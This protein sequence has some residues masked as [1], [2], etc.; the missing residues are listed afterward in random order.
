MTSRWGEVGALAPLL[1][2]LRTWLS[3]S[4]RI[5]VLSRRGREAGAAST[6][7]NTPPS[8]PR[9]R[10]SILARGTTIAARLP[11]PCGEG[12]GSRVGVVQSRC[13]LKD[14]LPN[15]PRK[16]EGVPLR[17]WCGRASRATVH[18]P[19]CG[20]GWQGGATAVGTLGNDTPLRHGPLTLPPTSHSEE[21]LPPLPSHRHR[22]PPL[23]GAPLPP[24]EGESDFLGL[25]LAKL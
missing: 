14:P 17:L 22:K 24:C 16:G 3:P 8:F 20:G 23:P 1:Q 4:P 10:E 25:A 2:I 12:G 5:C 6:C 13:T 11:P 18:L 9:T 19:P 7:S 15:P 21:P